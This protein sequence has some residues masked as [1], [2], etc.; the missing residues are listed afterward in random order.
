MELS[1][2]SIVIEFYRSKDTSLEDAWNGLELL[3]KYDYMKIPWWILL[4]Q[5]E[6]CLPLFQNVS[7]SRLECLQG[8]SQI[9]GMEELINVSKHLVQNNL[10]DNI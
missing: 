3:H 2:H 10:L 1:I 5:S 6:L 9:A 4:R 8:V 7:S